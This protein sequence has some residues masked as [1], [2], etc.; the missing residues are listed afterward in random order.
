M[1]PYLSAWLSSPIAGAT[2]YDYL[3]AVSVFIIS[4]LSLKLLQK[5]VINSL[6]RLSERTASRWDDAFVNSMQTV[7]PQFY[8]FVSF[9]LSLQVL[10]VHGAA[11]RVVDVILLAWVVYQIIAASQIVADYLIRSKF[12]RENDRASE[13][14]SGLL[15]TLTKIAFWTLGLLFVLSNV[16]VNVNSLIAGLGIGG[17]AVALAAQNLLGDLFGSLAIYF[18]RPF[19]PGDFIEVGDE[20]GTVLKVGIKTT[21]LRALSG[22]EIIIANRDITVSRIRNHRRMTER[23][24]EMRFGIEPDTSAKIVKNITAELGSIISSLEQV[25]FKRMTL[26]EINGTAIVFEVVFFVK[27][28]EHSVFAEVQQQVWLAI[29]EFLD[30]KKIKIA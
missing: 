1:S 21:R 7:K 23:R 14:V 25:R 20:K 10:P 4:G 18:D 6:A 30:E 11:D 19:V 8:W 28:N 2:V 9:Y 13:V 12:T 26:A 27:S 17:L 24:V 22:E 16:G 3:L 15:G 29:H 5:I